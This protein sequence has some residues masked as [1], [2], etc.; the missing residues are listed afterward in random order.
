M[1][2]T[3]WLELEQ[4]YNLEVCSIYL[5]LVHTE[6]VIDF[7]CPS[8]GHFTKKERQLLRVSEYSGFDLLTISVYS[9]QIVKVA[10]VQT[11]AVS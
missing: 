6:E 1:S 10:S 9:A 11:L 7:I 2:S 8:R 3:E 5:L 4:H